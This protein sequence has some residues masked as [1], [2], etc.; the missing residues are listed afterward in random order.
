MITRPK[1]RI[2][3]KLPGD[4]P[5]VAAYLAGQ[6]ARRRQSPQRAGTE[7]VA[8]L[9]ASRRGEKP[10]PVSAASFCAKPALGLGKE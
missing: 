4:R 6:A 5:V 8:A 1:R 3:V 2:R 7:P 10:L 9:I